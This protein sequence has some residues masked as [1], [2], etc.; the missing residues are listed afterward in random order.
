MLRLLARLTRPGLTL[1]PAGVSSVSQPLTLIITLRPRV[2][3]GDLNAFGDDM[4]DLCSG[5]LSPH[6]STPVR[7]RQQSPS[8]RTDCT[9]TLVTRRGRRSRAIGTHHGS[10]R[11][12]P[13]RPS[14]SRNLIP[15]AGS[16]KLSLWTGRC[17]ERSSDASLH[18]QITATHQNNSPSTADIDQCAATPGGAWSARSIRDPRRRTVPIGVS[19]AG[20]RSRHTGSIAPQACLTVQLAMIRLRPICLFTDVQS[21]VPEQDPGRD[22]ARL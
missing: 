14:T 12:P 13:H 5:A 16:A 7:Y 10:L 9:R 11:R 1:P 22:A 20:W 6:R 21:M 3:G 18:G 2:G 4:D 8:L 15:A 17:A 19:S